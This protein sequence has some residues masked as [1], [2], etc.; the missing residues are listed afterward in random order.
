M[1]YNFIINKIPVYFHVRSQ[2]FYSDMYNFKIIINFLF[3]HT[4]ENVNYIT[5]IGMVILML[6]IVTTAF[7]IIQSAFL[8]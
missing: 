8:I 6:I 2:L 1:C 5:E 7:M 4:A 3:I